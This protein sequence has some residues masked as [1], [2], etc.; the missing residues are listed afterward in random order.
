MFIQTFGISEK[1]HH[2]NM[3]AFAS[4]V[5]SWNIYSVRAEICT[6]KE[7]RL[8]QH[9]TKCRLKLQVE[10]EQNTFYHLHLGTLETETS[11]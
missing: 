3:N 10:S 11:L 1:K 6:G 4:S 9:K 8:V 5:I 7:Q 2:V